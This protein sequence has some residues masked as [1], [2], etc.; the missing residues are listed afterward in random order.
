MCNLTWTNTE[1]EKGLLFSRNLKTITNM[2]NYFSIEIFRLP[3]SPG[4]SAFQ[5]VRHIFS[6]IF[7]TFSEKKHLYYFQLKSESDVKEMQF[8]LK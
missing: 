6:R 7:E 3:K 8:V 2:F 1:V 5:Q 4:R